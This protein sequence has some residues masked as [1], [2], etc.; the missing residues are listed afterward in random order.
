MKTMKPKKSDNGMSD[1]SKTLAIDRQ[2]VATNGAV[3][4]ETP[5]LEVVTGAPNAVQA[6]ELTHERHILLRD[7]RNNPKVR[8]YLQKANEQMAAI[9]YSEHGLRHSALVAG[10]S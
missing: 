2:V 10:I 7:V 8:V 4:A 6:E 5:H 3:V 9:G 1:T